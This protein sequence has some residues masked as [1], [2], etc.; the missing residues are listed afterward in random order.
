LPTF[1]G[2]CS[3]AH[4]AKRIALLT[5]LAAPPR[6]PARPAGEVVYEP[7]DELPNSGGVRLDLAWPAGDAWW[8][9]GSR[10]ASQAVAEA[11]ALHFFL[12]Y[13]VDEIAASDAIS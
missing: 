4:F 2:Q 9:A 3:V 12:G 10:R 7:V 6:P 5:A 8:W 13:T 11:L 1:R